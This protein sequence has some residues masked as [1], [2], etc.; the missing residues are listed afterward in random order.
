MLDLILC[1]FAK[2]KRQRFILL[3]ILAACLFPIPLTVL[4]AKD[5]LHF[6]QLFKLVVT[7]GNFLLLPCVLSVA[8]C[9]LF[10]MERDSDMLKNLMT[11]PVPKTKLAA[12]KLAVLLIVAVLYSM[13]G[14]GATIIGGLVVGAVEGVA[15]KLG[16]SV[17]LG[18]MLFVSVLPVV[19][20]IVCFNKSYIFSIIIAFLY[21]VLNFGIALNM[22]SFAPNSIFIN[23]LPGPVIM[24]WWSSYWSGLSPEYFAIRKPYMLSTPVCA[25][26]LFLIAAISMPLISISYKKQ[27]D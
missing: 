5:S 8:A 17:I 26:I 18:I 21:S 14:L 20:L 19:I 9:V 12:A 23:I 6:E 2:I 16:L 4:V 7:F 24:R 22:M 11:V 10:F 1:E 27:E 15:F 3:S 25:G 13:A